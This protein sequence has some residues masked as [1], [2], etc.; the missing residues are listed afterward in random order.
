MIIIT[1]IAF[2]F[3]LAFSVTIH[4][5]G[6]F[7]IAKW[8]KIP[9][10]KFSL[11]F[12]PPIYKKMIGET[13]FRIAVFPLGGY[14]KLQ[15]EEEG[16]I[17]K[18]LKEINQPTTPISTPEPGNKPPGFYDVPV[19]RRIAVLIS[20]PVF[21]II[22]ALLIL[23]V[24]YNVY[25]LLE[26]PFRT[27]DVEPNSAAERLGFQTGDSIISIDDTDISSWDDFL[28]RLD[29][30]Q[31]AHKV[32]FMRQGANQ[33]LIV[34]WP[35]ESIEFKVIIP[36]IIGQVRVS[37]PAHRA[38]IKKG[39]RVFRINQQEINTWDELWQLIRKSYGQTLALQYLRDKDTL[40]A[41][42]TPATVYDPI[43][44]DTV[45]QIGILMTLV[46]RYP[47][48]LPSISMAINRGINI[49]WLTMKTLYELIIGKISRKN[50][51]GPIAIA[52]LSGESASW[53]LE[54]LFSLLALISINL[55]L[56]NLF[57]LPAFDGGQT[58]IALFEGIRRKKLS[59]RTRLIIQNIG[60]ALI[61]FLIIYVTYN[62]LTR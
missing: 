24:I 53:G 20:G 28:N 2:L 36:P 42:V 3:I 13:D 32:S 41:V 27:L 48:F 38:G 16:E 49:I 4:E 15:D 21:N 60:Y 50:L 40:T 9:V 30:G 22:S 37:G 6:H 56:I 45:G 54:N 17:I 18:S 35:R 55:G 26:T 52:R 7:I 31:N 57:P 58:L 47:G 1:I 8:A 19:Y 23:I 25:G 59:R 14:V 39:D 5:F 29:K 43:R 34:P 11:G 33:V 44:K 51:G 46:R 12:G 10:E 61:L 62:D